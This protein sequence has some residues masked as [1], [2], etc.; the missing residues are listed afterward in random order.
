MYASLF[1][2]ILNN[3]VSQMKG[4]NGDLVDTIGQNTCPFGYTT[5]KTPNRF[6]PIEVGDRGKYGGASHTCRTQKLDI[7]ATGVAGIP[8]AEPDSSSGVCM[9]DDECQ[10]PFGPSSECNGS[11]ECTNRNHLYK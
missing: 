11:S 8:N 4:S 7:D 6:Q 1:R 9:H 2:L 3:G 10:L 5:D